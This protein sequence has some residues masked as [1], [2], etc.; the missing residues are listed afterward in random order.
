MATTAQAEPRRAD[1]AIDVLGPDVDGGVRFS[2]SGRLLFSDLCHVPE[3]AARITA[4]ADG[5]G[6]MR[7]KLLPVAL[8]ADPALARTILT[9]PTGFRQ[10]RGV[11]ALAIT[12][13]QGLLTSSGELHR[14]QRRLVQP[15]FHARRLVAYAQDAV[16]LAE[17]RAGEWRDGQPVDL[18]DEMSSLT[19]EFVGRTLFGTDVRHEVAIVADATQNLL[20]AFPTLM[21]L[22][23]MLLTRVPSPFR[24]RLRREIARLDGVVERVIATRGTTGD[25]GDVVSML[26]AVR[27]EETGEGMPHQQLRDEVLTLLLAGHETTAVALSWAWYELWRT[28]EARVALDAELAG[29]AAEDGLAAA[30]W[31]GLPVTRAIVA[32]TLRLH[33]PAYILG[34]RPTEDVVVDRY[35]FRRNS[36]VVISPFAL[37]RDE[38]SWGPD[39]GRFRHT[40]WL[41]EDGTFDEGA[42]GQPRGAYLPFGAGSRMCIGAGFAVMEAVLLLARLASEWRVEFSPGFEPTPRPAVTYRPGAMPA[43]LR[44]R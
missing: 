34:R 4:R 19:L 32:E 3:R 5:V 35:R 30:S 39:A 29:R 41:R 33:P 8:V 20:E 12:F 15:A 18:A 14:R 7:G 26:L 40:R 27:D 10:G 9:R 1:E 44:A 43:V 36:A 28:P 13:G 23:G 24:H 31:D 21:S 11:E 2:M 37:H 6:R 38:R 42:P 22:R 25:T 17:A 16:R